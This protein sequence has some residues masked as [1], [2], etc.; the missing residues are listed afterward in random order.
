MAADRVCCNCT[1][2][3]DFGRRHR[4]GSESG[5]VTKQRRPAPR[6]IST[7]LA[8]GWATIAA[9]AIVFGLGALGYSI[10]EKPMYSASTTLYLTSG[11]T[12][13]PSAYD[14]LSASRERVGS[15]AQLLYTQ[16]VLMPA[17]QAAGLDLTLE[18]ARQRVAV[19]VNPQIVLITLSASDSDPAVAQKFADALAKSMETTVSALE[20]PGASTEPL[21][22]VHQ[23]TTATVNAG[24]AEPRT[25]MNVAVAVVAGLVVGVLLAMLREFLNKRVR[26]ENDAEAAL[27]T[28]A[29]A[30]V[31]QKDQAAEAFRAVRT[32][33]AVLTPPAR[34]LLLTSGRAQEG[35][36]TTTLGL[37]R[38]IAQAAHSVV[39][40]DANFYRPDASKRLGLDDAPGLA[41]VL[42]GASLG[43]A[44]QRGVSGV[45]TLSG[46]GAGSRVTGHPA[47]YFASAAFAR[48][49]EE[50]SRQFDYVLVDS[51]AMLENSGTDAIAALVDGV[52]MVSRRSGSTMAD[53]VECKRRLDNVEARVVGAVF[54]SSQL[55]LLT[56]SAAV[57][58]AMQKVP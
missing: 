4:R 43:N 42:R 7:V 35:T 57:A 51:E 41:D 20:V 26:D 30:V 46:L 17:A 2:S 39:I 6:G 34:T 44:L 28:P 13:V 12:I 15:Y 27:G 37:G 10:L 47:D 29:L 54:I 56:E 8:K 21:V 3:H 1:L 49:L 19:D 24:P 53:L 45:K 16:A 31:D 32:R 33:L 50:L 18:Q 22:K 23:V 48:T 38:A 5:M 36:T 52:L 14:S 55:E 40:V 11:G 25:L 58:P 9:V